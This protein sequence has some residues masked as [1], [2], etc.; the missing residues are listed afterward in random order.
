MYIHILRT[1]RRDILVFSFHRTKS[2][3]LGAVVL[4]QYSRN[5]PTDLSRQ[6]AAELLLKSRNGSE[7]R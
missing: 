1:T 3:P 6:Y 7:N 4:D 2:S 5:S